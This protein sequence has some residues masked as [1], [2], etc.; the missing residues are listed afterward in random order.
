MGQAAVL[1]AW[2]LVIKSGLL[3]HILCQSY[4]T[5]HILPG[6]EKV[7]YMK[8]LL[9]FIIPTQQFTWYFF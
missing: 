9:R 3:Q 4:H 1:Q 6:N 7:I 2:T 8:L 5:M